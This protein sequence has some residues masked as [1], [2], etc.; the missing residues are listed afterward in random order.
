MEKSIVILGGMIL[1]AAAAGT[2]AALVTNR[3]LER[4]AASLVDDRQFVALAT[5]LSRATTDS[6]VDAR[7]SVRSAAQRSLA[8]LENAQG[9]Q[10]VSGVVVSADGWILFPS[11]VKDML[12]HDAVVRYAGEVYAV[13]EQK[14][15][16]LLGVLA[17]R[18]EKVSGWTPVDIAYADEVLAGDTVYAAA[19]AYEVYPMTMIGER[20]RTN[21]LPIESPR[22]L[23]FAGDIS[24]DASV[25]FTN[26]G[27][28]YALLGHTKETT[29]S[30]HRCSG[31]V[32]ALVRG[33]DYRQAFL[34][35]WGSEAFTGDGGVVLTAPPSERRAVVRDGALERAGIDVGDT[36]LAIDEVYITPMLSLSDILAAYTP[37]Q[38]VA[39]QVKR[40]SE[41]ETV[42]VTLGAS[43]DEI[44]KEYLEE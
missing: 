41:R 18:A 42:M 13:G 31:F 7:E 37:G 21:I 40:G 12:A 27:R 3:A 9:T 44:Y 22:S 29:I 25:L 15:D 38:T 11:E 36:I 35:G 26:D 4:Y 2:S 19:H 14:E 24:S 17:V 30:A 1:A 32:R 16:T 28:W 5:R 33:E 23:L 20:A 34:G 43:N 39:V 6:T 8:F 10:R